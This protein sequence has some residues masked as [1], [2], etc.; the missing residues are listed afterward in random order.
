MTEDRSSAFHP[1]GRT[2]EAAPADE[3][4][5]TYEHTNTRADGHTSIRTD[6]HT[7]TRTDEQTHSDE[8]ANDSSSNESK[9]S[10]NTHYIF[11]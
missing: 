7:N 9:N 8:E 1:P 4:S 11:R 2:D 5:D 10:I 6:E 3:H